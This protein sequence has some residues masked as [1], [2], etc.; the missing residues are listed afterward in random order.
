MRRRL[1]AVAATGLLF[2]ACGDDGTTAAT[3]P[4]ADTTDT[5][6]GTPDT[7]ASEPGGTVASTVDTDVP[8]APDALQF[9]A[10]L[11]GGG[12]LDLTQ[13]AGRTVALWFWAPT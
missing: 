5:A 11:V 1:L 13:F 6:A 10:P 2:A 3:T 8:A 7:A 12:T 9:S 4:A